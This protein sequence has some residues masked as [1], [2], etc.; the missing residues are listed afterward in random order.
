[1]SGTTPFA[2][3]Q[4]FLSDYPRT[5]FPLTTTS[6]LVEKFSAKLKSF[7][8]NDLLPGKCG[9][10]VQ[11]RCYSAKRG[12][13][14]RRTV[15]LDPAAE[16]F[17]YDLVFR[18]RKFFRPDHRKTRQSFGYRFTGG[19]P[20][21]AT[22][23]YSK[24]QIALAAA[25]SKEPLT[26]KAD[27]STF[28]NNIYHHDLV[29]A[30][31]TIN[32]ADADVEAAGQFFREIN[33][34]RSI[35][36]L[37]QGLHP[38]KVLGA[39]FLRFIDN[40]FKLRSKIGIRFLDDI[41]FFDADQD[42]LTADLVTLQ[43]LLGEKGLC[44]NESK[45]VF[46]RVSEIDLPKKVDEVKKTLLQIRRRRLTVSGEETQVEDY[47]QIPLHD[48]QVEY[49]LE[50]L[51]TPDIEESDA[52]L[53][54]VLLRDHA[55]DVFP[56]MLKI[57]AMYPGLT[58]NLYHYVRL[59]RNRAGLEHLLLQLL[60]SCP[61]ATEYQLFWLAKIAEDFLLQSPKIGDILMRAF[62]HENAT[63]LSRAKVLEIPDLR[64]G[65]PEL[66]EEV[67]RSARSDWEAWA[68]AA[69][70]RCH[71]AAGRNHLLTYFGKGSP[72]NLLVA[73]CVRA[74]H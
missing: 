48:S 37:P 23:A 14:L 40:S 52:E 15:K 1:M 64:F 65:L 24:Y 62:D 49:L 20:E 51:A 55:E 56:K 12:F 7:L 34:G 2:V 27:V 18:N 13:H 46:G 22:Q 63:L 4:Y 17:I 53:V 19:Q 3:E 69:G 73:D 33:A 47:V 28:F 50:L 43:E 71:S 9:F 26:F 5:L 59:V 66:R 8:Y 30:L 39:E 25:R 36:C 45:T 74:F 29:N 41:H 67:L 61:N 57:L 6:L 31:R 44:L 35:D 16:F 60:G 38:C 42:K 54:L 58:K 68:A 32:W 10:P 72:L 11:Q 21:S 70:S